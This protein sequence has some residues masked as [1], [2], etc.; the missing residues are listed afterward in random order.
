MPCGAAPG[1]C[2]SRAVPVL[3]TSVTG[4]RRGVERRI[5]LQPLVILRNHAVHLGLLQHYFRDQDPVRVARHP[6]GQVAAVLA[7]PRE[8]PAAEPLSLG[9][10]GWLWGGFG[11]NGDVRRHE[12]LHQDR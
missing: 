8:Q 2:C 3:T 1:G 12:D 7:V 10:G 4:A 9:G 5:A 6:P 11:Q